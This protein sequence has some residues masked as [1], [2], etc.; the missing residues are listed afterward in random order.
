VLFCVTSVHVRSSRSPGSE[1]RS[2]SDHGTDVVL[3]VA[4]AKIRVEVEGA[5]LREGRTISHTAGYPEGVD[6][7]LRR[8]GL[9]R[10]EGDEVVVI[11]RAVRRGDLV[12]ISGVVRRPDGYREGDGLR[13]VGDGEDELL[14]YV[15][16]RDD[17]IL[18]LTPKRSPWVIPGLLSFALG[19]TTCAILAVWRWW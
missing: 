17:L 5:R 14:L 10:S 8:G 3:Q 19:L 1:S 2:F 4:G 15:G 18:A 9:S 11:E 6:V 7:C 16:G 12:T 13:L